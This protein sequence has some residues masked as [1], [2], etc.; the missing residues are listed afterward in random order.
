MK[1][2]VAPLKSRYNIEA[3][4]RGLEI[5]SL[6]S[7]E[8]PALTL[9]QVVELLKVNKSTAYRVLS[10]LE[11]MQYLVQDGTTRQYR[12]GLKVLQLGFTAI[13]TLE[14]RQIA[15][16]YLEKL[17]QALGET[18]SL[19][20]RDGFH[21][22]YIDRIRN[23]SIVGVVLGVGSSLPAHCTALGKVLLADLSRN[24]FNKL[25]A[26]YALHA[27]T[28]N[29]LTTKKG[30]MAELETIRQRGYAIDNEELA[31]GLRAV[32]APIRDFSTRAIA[33]A[34]VTGTTLQITHQRLKDEIIPALIK[35]TNQI[36]TALGYFPH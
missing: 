8:R 19:V 5:L 32:S 18:V 35:T 12:P 21:T 4:A 11:A 6:F 30:L 2:S 14:L 33:A 9:S 24:E 22:I 17:S 28:P 25:L 3:L 20:V 1:P 23:Q 7:A 13:N 27:Y 26:N 10:T 31:S 29:T 36:S 15:R 16:P 34:N